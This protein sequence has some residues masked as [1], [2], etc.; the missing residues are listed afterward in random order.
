MNGRFSEGS[1]DIICTAMKELKVLALV[2]MYNFDPS[3]SPGV[4][5]NLRTLCLDNSI[6]YG[7]STDIIGDLE[8]LE[9]LSFRGCD[10]MRELPREFGQLKKLRLLDMTNCTGLQ[11]IPNAYVNLKSCTCLIAFDGWELETGGEDKGMA[12][13]SEVM[14]LSDHLKF[15][16]VHI[17]NVIHLLP[18]DVVLKSLTIR[19]HIHLET[20]P[21]LIRKKKRERRVHC[22]FENKLGVVETQTVRLLVKKSESLKLRHVKNL[23]V[24]TDL[25]QE[26]IQHLKVLSLEDCPNTEYL[27]NGTSGT[28]QILFPRMQTICVRWMLKLKA[29]CPNNQ[30]P[31]SFLINL[32]S[33]ELKYCIVLKYA[34]SLLVARN[35]VQLQNLVI[36]SCDQM[37]EIVSKQQREHEKAVDMIAFHKLTKLTL[38][39][40]DSFVGFFQAKPRGMSHPLFA[41]VSTLTAS[42]YGVT[43]AKVEHQSAGIFEKSIFPSKCISWLQSIEEVNMVYMKHKG[44]LFDLKSHIVMD[45]QVVPIF[46]ELCKL[47]IIRCSF[48]HL[49]KN[50]PFGFQAFQNLRYLEIKW[51]SLEFVFL[52]IIAG[53]L[54]N[55]E[56]VKISACP[57]MV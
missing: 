37:G 16:A 53:K 45:G 14:S 28:Q 38:Q 4:L 30:L 31:K 26:G 12:S 43:T 41:L 50:I 22:A 6:F 57:D 47:V 1:M 10:S 3:R 9:I 48:T 15:L 24:L 33:L 34:F 17:P 54:L 32:R 7:L 40:L 27:A 44:V 42:I 49:W 19:F 46:S 18:K 5:K 8:N 55:L 39:R 2:E 13:I 56:E 35:L 11:L 21:D 20:Q 51:C 52:L 23:Y 29:I 36:S 25:D